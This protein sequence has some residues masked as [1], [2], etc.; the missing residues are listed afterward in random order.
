MT[1]EEYFGDWIKVID[2]DELFKIMRWLKTV[3]PDDLCPHPHNIFKAFR[4]CPYNECKVVFL[5][6]DPYPQRGVA[7]GILFG[8]SKETPEEC[9]SPSLR[10]IKE[11]AI[12][13]TIPHNVIEFDNTLESWAKQGILMI[14]TALTCEV[15]RI[16]SHYNIWRPFMSK[17]LTNMSS[18]NSGIVYVLFGSQ[19][20]SFQS[21]IVGQQHILKEY[22]PAYYARTGEKMSPSLFV[23]INQL[24]GGIYGEKI[25]F[26]KE[27][28]YG[29]C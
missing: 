16:G 14:N 21:C 3:N 2:K 6:Q 5:G 18:L 10:V 17:L 9:L 23:Q 20:A 25:N 15:N 11:A 4:V 24:L 8:N 7:Q 26:Y 19:A 1:A 22:H 29:I 12:D 28:E 13:Y 27:I